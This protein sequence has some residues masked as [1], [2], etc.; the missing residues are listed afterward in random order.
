MKICIMTGFIALLSM[1]S[2]FGQRDEAVLIFKDGSTMEGLA[3]LTNREDIK[4]KKTRKAKRQVYTFQEVDTLKI[5]FE[6]R[7]ITYT[8]VD[9]K[10]E[11]EPELLEVL[12][13]QGRVIHYQKV[14]Y[15]GGIRPYAV[16]YT[17]LRKKGQKKA[18][19][20]GSDALFSKN[21][22]RVAAQFFNDCE[23]LAE[24][25]QNGQFERNDLKEI[26][27]RYNEDCE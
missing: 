26:I 14:T 12:I 21:F 22:K 2:L 24:Q 18:T 17:F 25:I 11:S 19:K 20:F 13:Q 15:G 3:Q 16:H 7:T 10:N 9:I 5:F 8:L 1:T 4:F 23:E 27:K 6:S